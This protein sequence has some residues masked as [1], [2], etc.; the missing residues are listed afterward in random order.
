MLKK[1][2]VIHKITTNI[3]AEALRCSGFERLCISLV[4]YWHGQL[5]GTC[6]LFLNASRLL[7]LFS[8]HIFQFFFFVRPME[9]MVLFQQFVEKWN[10][11][12]FLWKRMN[13][14]SEKKNVFFIVLFFSTFWGFFLAFFYVVTFCWFF[15]IIFFLSWTFYLLDS[16]LRFIRHTEKGRQRKWFEE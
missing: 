1:K 16:P 8:V 15:F 6:N 10:E 14:N 13:C 7:L 11:L 12:R 2:S 3:T 9:E 4:E 5:W